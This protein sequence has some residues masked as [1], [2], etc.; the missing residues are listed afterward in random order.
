MLSLAAPAKLNLFLHILSRRQDGY[1]EIQTLFQLLDYGDTLSFS[2]R[3]DGQLKLSPA[4]ETIAHNDNLIIKAAKKLQAITKTHLGADIQLE[5]RLPLGGGLGGGSSDAATT[6]VALN[7][8]WQTGLTASDLAHLGLDLGADVPVFIHGRSAWAEG[9][10]E[11]LQTVVVPEH[12]YLVVNPNCSVST[13][14]IFSCQQL[15]RSTPP[16]T[17]A[18]FLENGGNNDCTATVTR[19]YPEVAEAMSW[20]NQ[21]ATAQLTGTGA[22]LFAAF[23]TKLAAESILRKLPAKWQGFVAKGIN[24]SPVVKFLT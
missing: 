8:L 23:P 11:R 12:W 2:L 21:H 7:H 16:I 19:L 1:H 24:R 18:G 5:K 13:A 9:I 10:G 14:Q 15:T 22:C 3:K 20:L 4:I 6:L 17:V